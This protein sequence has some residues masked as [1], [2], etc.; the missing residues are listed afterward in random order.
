MLVFNPAPLWV[1]GGVAGAVILF[2]LA[3]RI[4]DF[5]T[6]MA[7]RKEETAAILDAGPRREAME[8]IAK[9]GAVRERMSELD[10]ALTQCEGGDRWRV[11][12]GDG[13]F[14]DADSSV[15][16][17][18]E[19]RAKR[20][21]EAANGEMISL[22]RNAAIWLE[23]YAPQDPPPLTLRERV[24]ETLI[25]IIAWL[26]RA[27]KL[28]DLP[29]F[30]N[31]V[32][33]TRKNEKE[34]YPELPEKVA[35]ADADSDVF[36]PSSEN[37]KTGKKLRI[38][39]D[40][41]KAGKTENCTN[42]AALRQSAR[43]LQNTLKTY[44]IDA[45]LSGTPV[46]G[47]SVTQYE[48]RLQAGV[49]L[50]KLVKHADDIALS[51]GVGDVRIAPVPGKN[52]VVGIEVPNPQKTPVLLRD[53]LESQEFQ[54]GPPTAFALG[55]GIDGETVTANLSELP[56]VLIAG[57][58]G[59]GKSV[60]L[61]A[62]IVSLLYKSSPEQLR[63][64]MIDPKRV[65]LT[66][67]NGLPNLLRPVI[68]DP[69]DAVAALDKAV[70]EMET[71]YAAFDGA[72]VRTLDEY[73]KKMKKKPLPRLA[74]VIDEL[75]DLMMT[76]GKEVE[77]SS[78]R[79]AQMGRAAGMHL[80][81]A[82]QRPSADVITGLMKSNIPSRISLTVAS[83]MESRI[84]LDATGAEKLTGN[85][86]ML[87][88]PLGGEKKR[89]Q[90]CYV[91]P[92]EIERVVKFVK[93]DRNAAPDERRQPGP[94]TSGQ[95]EPEPVREE[96]ELLPAAVEIVL[97]TGQASVSLLQRRLKLGYSR[98]AR[99]VDQMELRGYV[100]PFEGSRPRQLLITR[101]QWRELRMGAAS[102]N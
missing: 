6:D 67:Y 39:L 9:L 70:K 24:G 41:L 59:S 11:G 29:F 87:Y 50:N 75:A 10:R 35:N 47:P 34:G 85:G 53:I 90:G 15:C 54:H 18:L 101:E 26:F 91:S 4:K 27:L 93:G 51:L 8:L 88:A 12:I 3:I 52:S 2:P 98:A 33:K 78:V 76:S 44:K 66:P 72:G 19:E 65:E 30:E 56:H 5:L 84:I 82:T 58:T 73:N 100:G 71:R 31:V 92:E 81:I 49:P 60:C 68:T 89:I 25:T 94:E 40:L 45:V 36:S 38:P 22:F 23:K 7:K 64:I 32:E 16:D 57:T 1:I 83:A 99:L 42:G 62:L 28:G 20:N 43:Q 102:P 79:I 21:L 95:E 14:Q 17:F 46:V 77:A 48:F 61:N 63:F 37:Q 97:E 96:D 55:R 80:V 13:K 69:E 74:I 86:D